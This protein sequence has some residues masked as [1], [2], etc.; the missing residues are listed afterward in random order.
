M[1]REILNKKYI[2]LTYQKE[3]HIKIL[4]G[5]VEDI[6]RLFIYFKY[7]NENTIRLKRK[8]IISMKPAIPDNFDVLTIKGKTIW[9][10]SGVL[11]NSVGLVKGWI[12]DCYLEVLDIEKQIIYYILPQDVQKIIK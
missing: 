6:N 8:D 1:Q 5:V 3:G 4:H 11:K 12:Y 9:F 10:Q 7:N 2:Q